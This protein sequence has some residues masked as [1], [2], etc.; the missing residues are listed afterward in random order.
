[1]NA[2]IVFFLLAFVGVGC[3]DGGSKVEKDSEAAL[4]DSLY[5]VV[6]KAHIAAMAKMAELH[7]SGQQVQ[8]LLDSLDKLPESKID[9]VYRRALMTLQED[10]QYADAAMDEWMTAFKYDSAQDDPPQRVK[11]LQSEREK[12]VKVRDSVLSAVERARGLLGLRGEG[13]KGG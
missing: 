6:D 7:R 1:M 10:L 8:Q 2:R 13:G 12:V 4:G 11:Y 9:T 3:N 5:R